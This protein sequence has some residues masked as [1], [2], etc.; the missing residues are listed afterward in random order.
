[1]RNVP[2]VRGSG[3]VDPPSLAPAVP[4]ELTILR[5]LLTRASLARGLLL[6]SFQT[7]TWPSALLPILAQLGW[8][9]KASAAEGLTCDGCDRHCWIIPERRPRHDGSLYQIG[10]AHV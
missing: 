5:Q 4:E 3:L 1:M 7:R 9:V 2:A 10:R 6:S 8:V